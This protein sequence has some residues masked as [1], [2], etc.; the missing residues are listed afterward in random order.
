MEHRCWS[1]DPPSNFPILPPPT[2][3]SPFSA[4]QQLLPDGW[5]TWNGETYGSTVFYAECNST[6]PGAATAR[7]PWVTPAFIN[8]TQAAQFEA[9]AFLEL[10]SWFDDAKNQLLW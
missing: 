10:S 9:E 4:L 8:A 7:A 2:P 5:N 1:L 3:P 6:G